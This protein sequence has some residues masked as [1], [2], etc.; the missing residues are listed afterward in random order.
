M[1]TI[2]SNLAVCPNLSKLGN[3]SS[4]SNMLTTMALDYYDMGYMPI[5]VFPKPKSPMTKLA[6]YQTT[7]ATPDDLSPLYKHRHQR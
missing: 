1:D 2:N 7:R 4:N 5:P 6:E 3:P